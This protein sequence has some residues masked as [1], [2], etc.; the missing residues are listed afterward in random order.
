MENPPPA[1]R[2][3]MKLHRGILTKI[4][5]ENS[6]LAKIGEDIGTLGEDLRKYTISRYDKLL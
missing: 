6:G 2:I 4:N 1:G 3:F 5:A